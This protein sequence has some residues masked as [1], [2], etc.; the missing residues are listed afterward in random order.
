M[1]IRREISVRLG[2]EK[3]FLGWKGA[4]GGMAKQTPVRQVEGT[5]NLDGLVVLP[6]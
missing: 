4:A 1:W 5:P 6:V 2:T 3:R